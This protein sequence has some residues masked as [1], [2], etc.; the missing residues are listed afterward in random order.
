MPVVGGVDPYE[1][2]SRRQAYVRKDSVKFFIKAGDC[3]T[4]VQLSQRAG[5]PRRVLWRPPRDFIKVASGAVF[6]DARG[7]FAKFYG[8]KIVVKNKCNGDLRYKYT[9]PVGRIKDPETIYGRALVSEGIV[10]P[11]GAVKELSRSKGR[12]S[13]KREKSYS[14]AM[15][16]AT[17]SVSE[18]SLFSGDANLYTMYQEK[19]PGD[20][21]TSPSYY[22]N[23]FGLIDFVIILPSSNQYTGE[24]FDK[25]YTVAEMVVVVKY[26]IT[27][28][29]A[30][31]KS[32]E[33]ND[34]ATFF[35]GGLN[36]LDALYH[37][38]ADPLVGVSGNYASVP[39][40]C[41]LPY[42][43]DVAY[44]GLHEISGRLVLSNFAKDGKRVGFFEWQQQRGSR[45]IIPG[46]NVSA[47]KVNGVGLYGMA[48]GAEFGYVDGLGW[49]VVD[50]DGKAIQVGSINFDKWAMINSNTVC[51]AYGGSSPIVKKSAIANY[52]SENAK[53]INWVAV[54]S[55]LTM[56]IRV[57]TYAARIASLFV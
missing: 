14:R 46:L 7:Q 35:M 45:L 36:S 31:I 11:T 49:A 53:A 40:V 4:D 29:G 44:V 56:T 28:E 3:I 42:Q 39:S 18:R 34:I 55:G 57:L 23:A 50:V 54:V 37:V 5:Q 47:V 30:G 33:E 51:I 17:F 21:V 16:Q 38:D 15:D 2:V 12:G 9:V 13:K 43:K 6:S 10:K 19:I 8:A 32:T 22:A 27:R 26:L 48:L 41:N 24:K 20:D 25:E 1:A 52:G